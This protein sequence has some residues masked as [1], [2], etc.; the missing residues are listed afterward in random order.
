ML[1]ITHQISRGL[2]EDEAFSFDS[3]Q[4]AIRMEVVGDQK[5]EL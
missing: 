4:Q 1:F 2:Q 3:K 5:N